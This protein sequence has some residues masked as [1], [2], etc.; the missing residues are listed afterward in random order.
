MESWSQGAQESSCDG[1]SLCLIKYK[2][3]EMGRLAIGEDSIAAS[4]VSVSVSVRDG[5]NLEMLDPGVATL[6]PAHKCGS[7]VTQPK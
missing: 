6:D 7:N 5:G 1:W 3:L 2:R 4:S